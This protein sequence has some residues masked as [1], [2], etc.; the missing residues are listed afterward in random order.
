MAFWAGPVGFAMRSLWGFFSSAL[1][2]SP[3]AVV[4]VEA[5]ERRRSS[6]TAVAAART[7][8][9]RRSVDG[10][11]T[12]VGTARAGGSSTTTG[13]GGAGSGAGGAAG[14]GATAG[15]GVSA[16]ASA[17]PSSRSRNGFLQAVQRTARPTRTGLTG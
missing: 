5:M 13:A 17:M 8:C 4:R 10:W 1:I 2:A 3:R 16:I 6:L 11:G 12:G 14:A 9:D 7:R 15:P